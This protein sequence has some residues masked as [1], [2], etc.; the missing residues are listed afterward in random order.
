MKNWGKF[1]F[2]VPFLFLEHRQFGFYRSFGKANANYRKVRKSVC[3]CVDYEPRKQEEREK[4]LTPLYKS[5][6]NIADYFVLF[7]ASN[8]HAQWRRHM[9]SINKR[10]EAKK[11]KKESN[12]TEN[13]KNKQQLKKIQKNN[14][15]M[16]PKSSSLSFFFSFCD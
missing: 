16:Y 2:L 14:E 13:T 6:S 8:N 9:A 15:G 12:I 1:F 4:K 7:L 5:S 11:H 10:R 3:V